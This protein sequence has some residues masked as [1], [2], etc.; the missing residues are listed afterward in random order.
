MPPTITIQHTFL[1]RVFNTL[2]IYFPSKQFS[3]YTYLM[4]K[5][6]SDKGKSMQSIDK[7]VTVCQIVTDPFKT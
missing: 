5:G 4:L 1:S 2:M 3:L 6:H 7:A